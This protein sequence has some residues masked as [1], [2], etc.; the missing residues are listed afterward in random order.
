MI[1][2]NKTDYITTATKEDF[3]ECWKEGL[4][5]EAEFDFDEEVEEEAREDFEDWFNKYMSDKHSP[6]VEC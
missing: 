3:W 6:M 5:S 2:P 1:N 4:M